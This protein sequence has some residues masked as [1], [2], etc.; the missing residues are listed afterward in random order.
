MKKLLVLLFLLA[1]V[2][3]AETVY[4]N[5]QN[6]SPLLFSGISQ[7]QAA[8]KSQ[9]LPLQETFSAPVLRLEIPQEALKHECTL[10]NDKLICDWTLK[11]NEEADKQI[12][13]KGASLLL[14]GYGNAQNL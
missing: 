3:L 11:S 12:Q 6:F 9:S 14:H 1:A 7:A 5:L 8:E 4:L 2:A 13:E 10:K